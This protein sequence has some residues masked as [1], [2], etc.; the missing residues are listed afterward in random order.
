MKLNTKT[1]Y[2]PIVMSHCVSTMRYSSEKR[3]PLKCVYRSFSLWHLNRSPGECVFGRHILVDYFSAYA[4]AAAT[5]LPYELKP[6]WVF[7]P[8]LHIVLYYRVAND[9]AAILGQLFANA[10][11]SSPFVR[12]TFEAFPVVSVIVGDYRRFLPS[13]RQAIHYRHIPDTLRRA[14]R[15]FL[16]HF[17]VFF[18]SFFFFGCI[19]HPFFSNCRNS[20]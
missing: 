16:Y 19:C 6:T 20:M 14:L 9:I 12:T 17:L 4:P 3:H 10:S 1:S 13:H 18:I 8:P 7:C 15:C 5:D 11:F 2:P